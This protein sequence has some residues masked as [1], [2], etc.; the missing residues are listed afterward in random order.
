MS[1]EHSPADSA[2]GGGRPAE[3]AAQAA[4]RRVWLRL[5]V[6]GA[7]VVAAI[8]AASLLVGGLLAGARGLAG[9]GVGSALAAVFVLVSVG[10]MYV[11]RNASLTAVGGMLGIGFAFKAFIFMIIVWNIKDAP[12]LSGPVAFFTIVAAVLATSALEVLT[13]QRARI[14]YVDPEAG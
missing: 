7:C 4:W 9:A 5:L 6:R 2:A 8:A 3:T 10:V 14:P 1:T 13:V 11:G 12:W